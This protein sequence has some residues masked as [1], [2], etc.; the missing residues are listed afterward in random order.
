VLINAGSRYAH[1]FAS[2]CFAWAVEAV[3]VMAA[4]DEE[5]GPEGERHRVMWGAV[6]GLFT[7]WLP[8]TRPGDGATLGLG[9]FLYFVVSFL[10]RK[11]EWRAVAA[12]AVTFTLWGGV[13]LVILRLQMGRWFATGYGLNHYEWNQMGFSWPKPNDLHWAVPIGTGSYC[14]WPMSPAIGIGGLIAALRPRG[15]AVSFMLAVSTLAL[16]TLYFFLEF[17]RGWDF[18]YGPRYQLPSLV[19]MSVGA[20]VML[21]PLWAAARKHVH[22]RRA[23]LVGGPALVGA[24]AALSGTVRLAPLLYP[25]NYDDTR[26]RS[27][28]NEAVRKNKLKNA[29]VWI[30]PG[31]WV[32]DVHDLTQNLPTELYPPNVLLLID[33]GEETRKCVTSRFPGRKQYRAT[34]GMT[35]AKLVPE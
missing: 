18:G 20:G 4:R 32:S 24:F 31:T 5:P 22:D 8:A 17:G 14:W 12:T 35:E 25:F 27:V 26:A 10:R 11:L 15:R 33:K 1:I 13:S 23:L 21:G 16:M 28:L 3:A 29:I 30:Q 7:A 6:L 2:M 19:A 9:V 34:G